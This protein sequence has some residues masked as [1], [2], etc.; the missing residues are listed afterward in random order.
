MTTRVRPA[1]PDDLPGLP[2]LEVASDEI[3]ARHGIGPIPPVATTAADL[4]SA[5]AVLVAEDVDA[6]EAGVIGFA[7]LEV[8]DGQGH[9]EQ[10]SVHPDASHRGAGSA[11]LDAAVEW[12]ARAG[13]DAVTLCTFA[14]VPWNA[15]FYARRGFTE[16]TDP[17]LG[18]RSRRDTERRL[19]LD[20]VGRRVV[21]SRSVGPHAVLD[22]L[23]A[24]LTAALGDDLLGLWL[25]GSLVAG[26]FDPARSDLDVFAVLRGRPDDA[27]LAAV[28][29]VHAS[30]EARHPGWRN[31]VE[32]ETCGLPTLLALS[33]G[34]DAGPEDV[35]MRLSPGETLHLLPASRH[36]VLTWTT[37]R[38]RGRRLVG[39]PAADVLP[40]VAPDLTRAALLEHVRDW[41]LWVEDIRS[42]GGQSY[43]VLSLCRAWCAVVD[44][45]QLSKLAASDRFAAT[46]P[47]DA[48]LVAWARDWWYAG[49]SDGDPG[50]FGEV[51]H[52]V[53]RTSRAILH[54]DRAGS[55][56]ASQPPS[57]SIPFS[58]KRTRCQNPLIR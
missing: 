11:L 25:H 15:P 17:G 9:L 13:H 23:A 19:G 1:G 7:R 30:L 27:T 31:R 56:G 36:R 35:I 28:A 18:V 46:R 38:E 14:E 21:L 6:P 53:I 48:D 45:E 3:F 40:P 43:A 29:P 39:P 52:F 41:P 54:A 8:V 51:R 5:A 32:V 37:V 10:L 2:A 22:D 24:G 34:A 33:G 47:E 44:G 16:V 4:A 20:A 58:P 57:T 50:R 42:T 49:G 12:A 55:T 26:D